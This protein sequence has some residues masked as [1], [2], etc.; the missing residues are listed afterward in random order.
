MKFFFAIFWMIAAGTIVVPSQAQV[1]VTQEHNHLSRDGLYID[2]AFT[3]TAAANLRRDL[4]FNGTILGGVYAQPLYIENGPGGAAMIIVATET[5]DVYALNAG[6]GNVIWHRN[7]GPPVTS[8]LPCGNINPLGITG[9]PVVDLASRSLF[10]DAMI[11]G[12]TIKHLIFS[13]NVDTGATRSGWPVDVNAKARYNGLTFTSLIQNQRGALGLLNG[14]IYV[15]YSGHLGDCGTYRGWVVGVPI[16]NPSTVTAWATSAIGGGIWGHGGVASGGTNIFVITGNTFQTG[17]HWGGGEAIIRLQPGPVFSGNPIDYWAPTNWLQLDNGDTDLGGCG[18][19]V[20]T[21]NGATPSQLVLALGKDGKAYLLNRINLGGIRAP[22]AS[23]QVATSIRGQAAATYA[24]RQGTYFVFR[25]SSGAISAY[26]ITAT[27][28][29]TIVPAW[30]VSQNGQGSPWVTTTNGVDNAIVWAANS[31]NGDQRVRGFN[32]DTGAIVYAGG[33][34]NE[35]MNGTS[36][37][38][39]GIV[40]RGRMYFAGTNKVYAFELP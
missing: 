22:V 8:G 16:S 20:I 11:A 17:G 30:N 31:G 34:P 35:L 37:F 18:P 32:G 13:L 33:G 5:N 40:A 38:N 7:V 23:A 3:R 25:A 27:N 6:T 19:V 15:P 26:R 21:I 14:V 24:T 12:V 10:F 4:N 36:K 29:P 39:T 1:N 9:T 28:P 2:S